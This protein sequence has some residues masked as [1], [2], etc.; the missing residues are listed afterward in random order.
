[1]ESPGST[2]TAGA[3]QSYG[4]YFWTPRTCFGNVH[5]GQSQ[6]FDALCLNPD[7]SDIPYLQ[8]ALNTYFEDDNL[9][10]L[11]EP[12][13]L[14]NTTLYASL[15]PR[16]S[17]NSVLPCGWVH[18]TMLLSPNDLCFLTNFSVQGCSILHTKSMLSLH[19]PPNVYWWGYWWHLHFWNGKFTVLL[20]KSQAFL[21]TG[22]CLIHLIGLNDPFLDEKLKASRTCLWND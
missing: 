4:T 19:I 15:P 10:S 6:T 5:E 17:I 16:A 18:T 21:K 8:R 7:M 3:H 1:M 9:V 2:H 22:T 12:H 11:P 14:G 20:L 13:S